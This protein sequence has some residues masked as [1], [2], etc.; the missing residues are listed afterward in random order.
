[1][2]P[3]LKYCLVA[4][5]ALTLLPLSSCKK[6]PNDPAISFRSRT[7][8]LTGTWNLT[9]ASYTLTEIQGNITTTTLYTFSAGKM[10][11][12][13]TTK[14]G[15]SA[16]TTQNSSYTYTEAWTINKDNTFSSSIVENTAPYTVSGSWA[17]LG[18]DKDADLKKKEALVLLPTKA[19]FGSAITTN[20]KTDNAEVLVLD[21]L[22]N[23]ELIITFDELSD[24]G[25]A[26]NPD[27][28]TR[29]G[30]Y[31]YTQ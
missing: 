26:S 5:L 21:K 29:V 23:S 30:S 22:S 12:V 17:F 15:N 10:D 11:M 16:A 27:K 14:I 1:M 19:V 31:T 28:T 8:R 2:K 25:T 9:A 24:N 4:L 18:K 3:L 6:G 20:G 7:G 13:K